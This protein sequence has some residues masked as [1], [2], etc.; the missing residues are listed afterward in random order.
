MKTFRRDSPRVNAGSM[1]DIAFLLLIF[2]L[3]TTT[4]SADKGILRQLPADCPPGEVCSESVS[5]RN[6][7]KIIINIDNQIMVNGELIDISELKAMAINFIDNNGN[8]T[9]DYCSGKKLS[10]SSA[11]P[12]K[13]VV[14]LKHDPLTTYGK[15]I[16]VQ[17][18]LSK[19]YYHLRETYAMNTFNK[20]P[21]ELT[22]E[23]IKVLRK[24]YPFIL[25]EAKVRR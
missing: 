2:F 17:D 14:S 6:L 18:E 25:S 10:T 9:C 3:V 22:K 24:A 7:L 19:A 8:A 21:S 16:E 15:F 4:I 13:A 23:E 12:S 5:E 11:H 20:S 1:A